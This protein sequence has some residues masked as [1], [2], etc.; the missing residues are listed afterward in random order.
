[1][2]GLGL[3]YAHGEGVPQDY[4][5]AKERYQKSAATGN[6]RAMNDRGLLYDLGKGLPHDYR[7]AK[8]WYEKAKERC[9]EVAAAR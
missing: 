7:K 3:L 5:K 1:M 4:H 8:E 6:C 9:E 2:Y